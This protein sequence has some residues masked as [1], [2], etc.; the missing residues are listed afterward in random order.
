LD[1]NVYSGVESTKKDSTFEIYVRKD[2][3]RFNA[4]HFVAFPGFRERLH[5]HNYRVGVKLIG[6]RQL[7]YDGYVVDFG[8]VKRAVK[9][10]CKTLNE[11]FLLPE[12]SKVIKFELNI[13][14]EGN[15]QVRLQ[16]ED[17][18]VFLFP[19]G[20]IMFLPIQ[21]STAEEIAHY[22]WLC[23]VNKLDH[24]FLLQRGVHTM[25]VVCEEDIGQEALFRK[26][27]PETKEELIAI[28]NLSKYIKSDNYSPRPCRL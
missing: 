16:C 24:T 23:I 20:D 5:G 11:H 8:D 7:G 9:E 1:T 10:V 13:T 25:E 2:T 21:H 14:G 3:F 22:L 19:K 6:C 17:G 12:F 26:T 27:I 15:V 4:A 18:A 28:S